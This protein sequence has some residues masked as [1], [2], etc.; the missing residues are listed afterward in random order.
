MSKVL[1]AI[2][3][4]EAVRRARDTGHVPLIA[5]TGTEALRLVKTERPAAAFL[6]VRMPGLDGLATLREIVATDRTLPVILMTAYGTLET[7]SE[8]LRADAFDYLGKP[9]ELE[10]V[11]QVLRRALHASQRPPEP[12]PQELA[13]PVSADGRATL[14]GQS[15]AMQQVFKLI[16]LL[17]GTELSVLIEGDSGVGKE[18]VARAIHT[19]G[20]RSVEPFV[21]VNCA[22]IPETLIESELFGHE[23]G[24]FTDARELRRGRF[25]AAGR[26]TLFLDEVSELPRHLQGKLLRALQ[27]RSFERIGSVTPLPVAARI[28]AATNRPR[29]RSPPDGS[30]RISIIGSTS[31]WCGCRR[32]ASGAKICRRCA[33][34]SSRAPPRNSAGRRRR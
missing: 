18:L 33:P 29:L 12:A 30:G 34:E 11:R 7:A 5:S 19:R 24:A 3:P 31:R 1:I 28:I 14:I 4:E 10:T 20:P 15:A 27:E 23:K 26:G 16:V 8:A 17:A 32:C 6:D 2:T 22:A 21:V 13:A 9:L 25:E